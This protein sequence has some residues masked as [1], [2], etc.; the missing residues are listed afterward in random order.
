LA[1][2]PVITQ[3]IG[4]IKYAAISATGDASIGPI[5]DHGAGPDA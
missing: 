5:H 1:Y 2:G 3:Q 4:N